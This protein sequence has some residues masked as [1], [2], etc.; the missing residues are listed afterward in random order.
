MKK[1]GIIG[2]GIMGSG[3]ASNFLK[4]KYEVY[5]WNRTKSVADKFTKKGAMVCATP[6]KVVAKADIV[7]EVTADDESSKQVW[8]G[9]K[10]ILTGADKTKILI[11]SATL[12]IKWTDELATLCKKKG[13]TFLDMPLTGSKIGADTGTLTLLCGG[14]KKVLARITPA[15]K[16]ISAKIS[17]FG[18]AGQGMRYKLILNYLQGL[19]MVGFGQAMRMARAGGMNLKKV[20]EEIVNKPGGIVAPVASE[21]YFNPPKKPSFSIEW[22]T[23]DIKYAKKFAQGLDVSLLNTTLN[24]YKKAVKK[25]L[26]DK[27]WS[28]VNLE[29][30]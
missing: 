18:L 3:M 21:A 30:L 9:K 10:G 16:A 27:D 26:K 29:E 6:A 13:V 14:D 12:S 7:F 2:L 15:L 1:I 11:A 24:E 17:Y 20:A 28:W 25:G 5:V 8:L 22:I 4:N 19:H 23:K